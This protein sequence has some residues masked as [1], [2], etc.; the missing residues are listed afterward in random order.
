MQTKI[1]RVGAALT[2]LFLIRTAAFYTITTCEAFMPSSLSSLTSSQ[3][4]SPK[5]SRRTSPLHASNQR[6]FGRSAEAERLKRKRDELEAKVLRQELLS[7]VRDA[8]LAKKKIER[9]IREAE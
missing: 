8:E 9:D 3:L 6:R 2:A 4:V 7:E 1:I 5:I